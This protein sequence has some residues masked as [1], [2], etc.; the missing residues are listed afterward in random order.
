MEK[1]PYNK[2]AVDTFD[3]R[4]GSKGITLDSL[5]FGEKKKINK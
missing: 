4:G 1:K 5:D 3:G 2:N